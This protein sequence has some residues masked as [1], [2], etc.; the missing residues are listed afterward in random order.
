MS[1]F[2]GQGQ[3]H[4]S[5]PTL[6][7]MTITGSADWT[8]ASVIAG[9]FTGIY[10]KDKKSSV[11]FISPSDFAALKS[12]LAGGNRVPVTLGVTESAG[13][14]V[15]PVS[16]FCYSGKCLSGALKLDSTAPTSGVNASG[17]A[18]TAATGT[19]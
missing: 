14:T 16:Q 8:S 17:P 4:G 6:I 18:I 7:N 3:D 2:S 12:Q 13:A 19:K 11:V 10:D 1:T 5:T 9:G 15:W